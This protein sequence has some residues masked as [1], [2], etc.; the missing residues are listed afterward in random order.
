MLPDFCSSE[1]CG[2]VSVSIQSPRRRIAERFRSLAMKLLG[3]FVSL[4]VVTLCGSAEIPTITTNPVLAVSA[5]LPPGWT[6]LK[7]EDNTYPFYRPKG[8]GKAIF[9][10][11]SGKKYL[12]EQFSAVLYIMPADYQDGGDDP[13]QGKAASWPARLIATTKPAKLY[14]WPAPQAEDWETLQKDLL[15]AIVRNSEDGPASGSQPFTSGTNT[16]SSASG[17]RR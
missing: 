11:I 13:T 9:L 7:V 2:H 14:L 10:G 8:S 17:S 6:I 5:V 4:V 12:K 16:T 1:C 3:S 15:K